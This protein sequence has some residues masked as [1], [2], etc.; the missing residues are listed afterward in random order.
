MAKEGCI[1]TG[2]MKKGVY[3]PV[4]DWTMVVGARVSE[5]RIKQLMEFDFESVWDLSLDDIIA[6]NN[7]KFQAVVWLF[8]DA[9]EKVMG[10][11]K[12]S[13]LYYEL[14]YTIGKKGWETI[15]KHFNTKKL[16]PTQVA[17]YQDMAHFFYG[18]HCQA[19]TE[20][21]EDTVVVT[22]Q[23]CLL[24]MP[25]KGMEDKNKYV[26][27][28][29]EGYLQAY[30]ELAPY[31]AI[32]YQAFITPEEMEYKVDLTKYPSFCAGKRAGG[33]LHQLIFKWKE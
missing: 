28:F 13:E 11:E 33:H 6:C 3:R 17:W 18:P 30:K 26:E 31:L 4:I 8:A 2:E 27:P 1:G 21:T 19:Y 12:T 20:Y 16:T 29:I 32:T 24:T 22:R 14:G 10:G 7:R 23:D 9:A 25:P 5:E 15:L